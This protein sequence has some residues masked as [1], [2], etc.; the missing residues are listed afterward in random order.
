MCNC[1]L[2]F[3]NTRTAFVERYFDRVVCNGCDKI[4]TI[5]VFL[6]VRYRGNK[7][8]YQS[9]DNRYVRS[10][11]HLWERRD[12]VKCPYCKDSGWWLGEYCPGNEDNTF[13]DTAKT[14]NMNYV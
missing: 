2:T 3:T 12:S 6:S 1:N 8:F 10:I 11:I 9:S 14:E 13:L 7:N 4:Y 5:G